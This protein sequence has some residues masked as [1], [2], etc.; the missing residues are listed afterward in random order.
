MF[1]KPLAEHETVDEGA[2]LV[3]ECRVDAEPA[4]TFTWYHNER[5]IKNSRNFRV[6]NAEE[7]RFTQLAIFDI[8][9]DDEGDIK[10]LAENKYGS[11]QTLAHV[12]V[13]GESQFFIFPS[14]SF[15]LF[16]L[17]VCSPHWVVYFQCAHTSQQYS[18]LLLLTP[19]LASL[20]FTEKIYIIVSLSSFLF[21]F[22]PTPTNR[23][24]K[25]SNRVR[26]EPI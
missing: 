13:N 17:L 26:L 24:A 8:F 7:V 12:Q 1:V 21:L 9:K 4:P 23:T 19:S 11:A 6:I 2:V 14:L 10:C 18:F 5:K 22:F 15:P 16:T 25:H 3:L 20:C